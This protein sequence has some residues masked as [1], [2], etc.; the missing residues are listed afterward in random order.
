MEVDEATGLLVQFIMAVVLFSFGNSRIEYCA[1]R[2]TE[3][4]IEIIAEDHDGDWQKRQCSPEK[5][6][7][8]TKSVGY[9][10]D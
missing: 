6:L 4:L 1:V 8:I 10:C 3:F 2:A 9:F 5:G 7:P